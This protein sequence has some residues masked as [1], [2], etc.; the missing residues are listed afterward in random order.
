MR[1]RQV[2]LADSRPRSKSTPV[3]FEPME[4]RRMFS[5]EFVIHV[6]IDGLRPDPITA[7]GPAQAPNFY[8]LRREGSFT[9]NARSDVDFTNTSPNQWGMMTGRPVLGAAG[10]GW[11]LN[12][13]ELPPG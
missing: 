5:A 13:D 2:P 6:S 8:K 9:D 4:V 11:V 7:L 1:P 3:A 12:A 10:H